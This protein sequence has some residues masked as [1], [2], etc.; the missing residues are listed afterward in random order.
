MRPAPLVHPFLLFLLACIASTSLARAHRLDEY[1]QAT[2]VSIEPNEIRLKIN[3]TP[4]VEVADQIL[5]RIDRNHDG[6]I[7]EK[8]AA[9]YYESLKHDLL[10][11][12]D[13][14]KMSLRLASSKFPTAGE[15]RTGWG[16][17][18]VELS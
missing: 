2:L 3:L 1:L 14:R 16:I 10:V 12:L 13:Q 15:L 5:E 11:N 17:I 6:A 4:G 9:A 7:S 8:E 18:Q